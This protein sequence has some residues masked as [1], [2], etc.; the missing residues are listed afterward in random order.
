MAIVLYDHAGRLDT[1]KLIPFSAYNIALKEGLIVGS[2][3]SKSE[4]WKRL[5]IVE[6]KTFI[7][8]QA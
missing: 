2:Q 3:G 5:N 8:S 6:I 7:A 4:N 1:T